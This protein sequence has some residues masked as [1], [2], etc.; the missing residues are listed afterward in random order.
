MR[1][2]FSPFLTLAFL[3][4]IIPNNLQGASA[5]LPAVINAS[6]QKL[7]CIFQG[8]KPDPAFLRA[9]DTPFHRLRKS[10]NGIGVSPLPGFLPVQITEG[11]SCP[12]SVCSG[13]YDSVV[14][15]YG[16]FFEYCAAQNPVYD[17]NAGCNAGTRD[18]ECG[19]GTICCANAEM[20]WNVNNDC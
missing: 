14:P 20:C 10:W 4:A 8:I 2:K 7:E 18:E 12:T 16:C 6:G 11:G 17:P 3:L 5:A 1:E 9:K 19:D 13:S 15:S